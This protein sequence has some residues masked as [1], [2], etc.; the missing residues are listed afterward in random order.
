MGDVSNILSNNHFFLGD[1]TTINKVLEQFKEAV[2]KFPK[3]VETYALYAQVMSD[4]QVR[5]D[6]GLEENLCIQTDLML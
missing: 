6:D 4:Q 2:E 3:C 5:A 1:N